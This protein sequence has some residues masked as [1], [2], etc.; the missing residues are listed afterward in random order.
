MD[1]T[2]LRSTWAAMLAQAIAA[3][4]RLDEAL[5][6]AEESRK[7]A[8]DDDFD[9]QSRWRRAE[10]L[11]MAARGRYDEAIRL[12]DEA[13]AITTDTED[14]AHQGEALVDLARALSGAGRDE[15]AAEVL[16]QA[17]ERYERKGNITS[18]QRVRS[19]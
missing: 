4:G 11:V 13:V 6:L 12:A 3:Q 17:L 1:E 18:A 15:E 19:Q 8:A 10:S 7:L 16:G 5:A 9:S 2:S 14:I